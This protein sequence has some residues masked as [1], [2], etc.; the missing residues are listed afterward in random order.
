M[1][2]IKSALAFGV[3]KPVLWCNHFYKDIALKD[4]RFLILVVEK[5]KTRLH[6]PELVV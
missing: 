3:W 6:L 4:L 2:V 5:E 1:T